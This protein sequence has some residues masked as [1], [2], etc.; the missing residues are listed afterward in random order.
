MP[1]TCNICHADRV[2][3]YSS[4][5]NQV[6]ICTPCAKREYGHNH[7]SVDSIK[8]FLESQGRTYKEPSSP[9]NPTK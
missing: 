5:R 6:F 7:A 4:G 2:P 3:G 8:A 9:S 1:T